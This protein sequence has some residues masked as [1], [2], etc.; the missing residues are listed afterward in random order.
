[1]FPF[2]LHIAETI[3]LKGN[4]VNSSP[5]SYF[6]ASTGARVTIALATSF[7]FPSRTA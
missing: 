5:A 4:Q 7:S 2:A 1:M 6:P 3:G